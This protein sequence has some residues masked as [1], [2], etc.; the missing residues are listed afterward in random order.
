MVTIVLIINVGRKRTDG[1]VSKMKVYD[2]LIDEMKRLGKGQIP[3]GIGVGEV[4]SVTPIKIRKN[5]LILERENLLIAD[6][7]LEGYERV[8][9]YT[10]KD[11]DGASGRHTEKMIYQDGLKVGDKVVLSPVMAGQMYVVVARV[12]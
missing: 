6:Y 2:E 7:L 11:K 9:E 4:L 3:E 12:I 8:M 1:Q 10:W 5:E